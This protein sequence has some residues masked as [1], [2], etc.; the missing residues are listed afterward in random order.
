[1]QA[2]DLVVARKAFRD[3]RGRMVA[4]GEVLSARNVPTSL[5]ANFRA[6]KPGEI[7]L[8]ATRDQQSRVGGQL[9]EFRRGAVFAS[10][11]VIAGKNA[12]GLE[13]IQAKP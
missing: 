6:V 11:H 1:M 8:R 13:S 9:I 2:R 5:A 7:L 3:G 10:E 4:V 12:L